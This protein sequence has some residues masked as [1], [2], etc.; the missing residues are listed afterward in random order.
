MVD[1]LGGGG[2]GDGRRVR[3]YEFETKSDYHVSSIYTSW[4]ACA[5]FDA[6]R[7]VAGELVGGCRRSSC[8][9]KI[10]HPE[11]VVFFRV[12]DTGRARH[13]QR[14]LTQPL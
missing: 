6:K 1:E 14:V 10:S 5:P 9:R 2:S 8:R 3:V 7:N 13:K 4:S 11:P 12:R